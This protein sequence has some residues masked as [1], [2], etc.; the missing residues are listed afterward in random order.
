MK[1]GRKV[2]MLCHSNLLEGRKKWERDMTYH[3]FFV[4]LQPFHSTCCHVFSPHEIEEYVLLYLLL[5]IAHSAHHVYV[6]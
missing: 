6:I 3:P 1:D 4:Y 5:L 2:K